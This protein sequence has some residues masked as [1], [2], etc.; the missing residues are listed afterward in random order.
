MARL[1][2]KAVGRNWQPDTHSLVSN[3]NSWQKL[4][5]S[6]WG[7]GLVLYVY[8]CVYFC[9]CC[10]ESVVIHILASIYFICVHVSNI[11]A[12]STTLY[13][14]EAHTHTHALSEKYA[15]GVASMMPQPQTHTTRAVTQVS[16]TSSYSEIPQ[17]K[18]KTRSYR[19][20]LKQMD[21]RSMREPLCLSSCLC[22][23]TW[24]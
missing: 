24:F 9:V 22:V 8:V 19:S 1:H 21:S 4:K 3:S 2:S 17:K 7:S 16:N 5:I 23:R 20:S 10:C 12:L 6:R 15:A 13:T 11:I 14:K 18:R